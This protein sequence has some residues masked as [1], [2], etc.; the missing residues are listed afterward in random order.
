[1]GRL[2]KYRKDEIAKFFVDIIIY[3][4]VLLEIIKNVNVYCKRYL[5]SLS[6]IN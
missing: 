3:T 4:P 1:M 5:N 6:G 2:K